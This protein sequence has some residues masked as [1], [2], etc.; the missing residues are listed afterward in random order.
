MIR[1]NYLEAAHDQRL[2]VEGV[3][4]ARRLAQQARWR[5]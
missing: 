3:K 1:A 4:Y 5:R 2:M